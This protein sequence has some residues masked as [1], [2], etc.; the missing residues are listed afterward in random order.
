MMHDR[1]N[2]VSVKHC[3][4]D[5]TKICGDLAPAPHHLFEG[6]LYGSYHQAFVQ[7]L[8][9][10]EEARRRRGVARGPRRTCGPA[11]RSGPG[12][13]SVRDWNVALEVGVVVGLLAKDGRGRGG[14]V[15]K[16]LDD[17]LELAGDVVLK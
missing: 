4:D 1:V 15:A 8:L 12:Q 17:G 11:Q 7:D 10:S 9:L 5:W 13:R 2:P 6:V 3:Q 16:D 14:H